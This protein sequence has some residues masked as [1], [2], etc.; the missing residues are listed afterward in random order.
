MAHVDRTHSLSVI[1]N[2]MRLSS[3]FQ[4]LRPVDGPTAMVRS[5]VTDSLVPIHASLICSHRQRRHINTTTKTEDRAFPNIQQAYIVD[6]EDRHVLTTVTFFYP[7]Y[8]QT[9]V[10][11]KSCTIGW[12][13]SCN[14]KSYNHEETI[15]GV[16]SGKIDDAAYRICIAFHRHDVYGRK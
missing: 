12:K 14:E 11:T 10:T 13:E 8:V 15:P 1:V 5:S 16:A 9:P 7:R 6:D 2:A 4:N 3:S